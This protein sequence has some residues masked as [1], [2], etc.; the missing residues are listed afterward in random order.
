MLDG[1]WPDCADSPAAA[2]PRWPRDLATRT[3]G[4]PAPDRVNERTVRSRT[5]AG[6]L[7]QM[8]AIIHAERYEATDARPRCSHPELSR[9]R[10]GAHEP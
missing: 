8:M 3:A 1:R 7:R 6:L 10:V 9:A 4:L 2:V 5:L